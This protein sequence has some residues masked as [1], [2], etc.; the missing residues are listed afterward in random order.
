MDERNEQDTPLDPASVRASELTTQL[1]RA[2][3][4]L[5]AFV[6]GH[7]LLD[8]LDVAGGVSPCAECLW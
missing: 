8:G 1:A 5:G 3:G 6:E 2:K 7:D 4:L